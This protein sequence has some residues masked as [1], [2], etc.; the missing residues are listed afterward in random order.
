MI[1]HFNQ[2][3]DRFPAA[4][5]MLVHSGTS[6]LLILDGHHIRPGAGGRREIL[7]IMLGVDGKGGLGGPT[8]QDN[9]VALVW[10]EEEPAQF[11]FRFLQVIPSTRE[12]LPMECS[13]SASA[14]AT[15]AQFSGHH[16]GRESLWKAV[17]LSTRQKIELRPNRHDELADA[18]AVRFLASPRT[19][20]ALAGLG[21]PHRVRIGNQDVIFHPVWLGNLFLFTELHPALCD[22]GKSNDIARAG[23][24]VARAAGL[25]LR[26][27]YHPKVIPFAVSSFSEPLAVSAASF[28]HGE[29]HRSLPGSAAMALCAFLA[30]RAGNQAA[31]MRDWRVN[32][33]SGYIDV[34]LGFN[35][36]GSKARLAW[37]EFVTPVSLLS[38]GVV[39][40]PWR[41]TG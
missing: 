21:G 29:L 3:L 36:K 14:A 13:N 12:V 6:R 25:P 41:R 15:L 20:K 28:Y 19:G 22:A 23:L 40:M 26:R 37:T 39:A 1:P 7:N 8:L 32:H 34:K 31:E 4:T 30:N 10:P 33:P 5:Y 9:K 38:W 18:W 27:G 24:R 35:H 2:L 11:R 17:N 16:R